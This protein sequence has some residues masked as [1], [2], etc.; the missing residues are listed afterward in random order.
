MQGCFEY[1]IGCLHFIVW[2]V[3]MDEFISSFCPIS[4]NWIS[5]NARWMFFI[6]RSSLVSVIKMHLNEDKSIENYTTN[7]NYW[8]ENE[9]WTFEYWIVVLC[10]SIIPWNRA[11][12]NA[13]IRNVVGVINLMVHVL[14]NRLRSWKWQIVTF[15]RY[16]TKQHPPHN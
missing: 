14:Q 2:Y 6:W 7:L 12:A 15:M 11:S 13:V 5:H 9:S 3:F 4:A 10:C 8:D 1:K 16:I